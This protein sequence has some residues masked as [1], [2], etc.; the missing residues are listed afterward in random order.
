MYGNNNYVLLLVGNQPF[1]PTNT[2]AGGFSEPP[3]TLSW[4]SGAP[5]PPTSQN[6]P[7]Q[8]T[9]EEKEDQETGLSIVG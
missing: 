9:H 2:M 1:N 4:S 8:K 7:L 5:M 3:S 6:L